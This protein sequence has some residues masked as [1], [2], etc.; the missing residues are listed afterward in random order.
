MPEAIKE[1]LVEHRGERLRSRAR[2]LSEKMKMEEEEAFV[3]I[4]EELL[5]IC[6]RN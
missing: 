3:E 6:A 2:E 5:K 1:V 4:A